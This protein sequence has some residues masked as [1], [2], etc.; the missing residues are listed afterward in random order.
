MDL[1]KKRSRVVSTTGAGGAAAAPATAGPVLSIRTSDLLEGS[2]PYERLATSGTSPTKPSSPLPPLPTYA[3]DTDNFSSASSRRSQNGSGSAADSY[4]MSAASSRPQTPVYTGHASITPPVNLIAKLVPPGRSSGEMAR[5]DTERRAKQR[6]SRRRSEDTEAGNRQSGRSSPGEGSMRS[7]QSGPS[8]YDDRGGRRTPSMADS[9]STRASVASASARSSPKKGY[10]SGTPGFYATG[11]TAGDTGWGSP[12]PTL[13]PVSTLQSQPSALPRSPYANNTS[14]RP[15]TLHSYDT[16]SSLD[17]V[18]SSS[19]LVY[20]SPPTSATFE[21]P[22]PPPHVISQRFN[23]LLPKLDFPR[24]AIQSLGIDRQWTLLYID[25][26]SKW[27]AAREQLT[28]KAVDR[29]SA[30][31]SNMAVGG[32][33]G[34]SSLRGAGKGMKGVKGMTENPEWYIS[35]FMDSSITK[36]EV[37]GLSVCL[38]TYSIE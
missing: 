17:S 4:R 36:E 5:E 34:D 10:A 27:T 28:G 21:F 38:R 16:S 30:M 22:R 31:L 6:D 26:H 37:T 35:K 33:S 3:G 25:E 23:E 12:S 2:T 32:S 29:R 14:R 8:R 24:D 18:A 13:S 7:V 20:I 1:F 11:S 9:V 15:S 19:T